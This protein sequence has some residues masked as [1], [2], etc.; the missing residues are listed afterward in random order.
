MSKE[1]IRLLTKEVISQNNEIPLFRETDSPENTAGM[2]LEEAQELVK[3]MKEAFVTDDLTKVAGELGDV[4][5]LALK[6]CDSLGLNADDVVRIKIARNGFKYKN[7]T[8]K[9]TARREW[10]M[11]DGDDWFFKYYLDYLAEI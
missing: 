1:N 7:Q 11:I 10:E 2:I 6:L 5:Y 4:L 3:E 9:E 8:D